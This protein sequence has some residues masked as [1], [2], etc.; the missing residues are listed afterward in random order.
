MT[1]GH[2][3]RVP[4]DPVAACPHDIDADHHVN[5]DYWSLRFITIMMIN[6]HHKEEK[7]LFKQ[8][9]IKQGLFSTTKS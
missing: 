9:D 4:I 6:D 8:I 7:S 2:W 3:G 5:T 1:L